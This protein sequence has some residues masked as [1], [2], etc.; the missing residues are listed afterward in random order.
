MADPNDDGQIGRRARRMRLL[1]SIRENTN[2]VYVPTDEG[3]WSAA[4]HWMSVTRALTEN[5]PRAPNP[6]GFKGEL[7]PPQATMLRAMLDL[8]RCPVLHLADGSLAQGSDEKTRPP[9]IQ[10]KWG[11]IGEKFSF[12]K[13]VLAMALV[14]AT[15]RPRALPEMTNVPMIPDKPGLNKAQVTTDAG[16]AGRACVLTT[17]LNSVQIGFMPELTCRF[18][19]VLDVTMVIAASAVISQW[20]E[21]AKRF[22]SLRYFIIENVATLREFE[23]LYRSGKIAAYSM[24]MVKAGKVTARFQVDGEPAPREKQTQR[25][26]I[27]AI[28]AVIEGVTLARLII[29]DFDTIKLGSDDCFLPSLFTWIIS[30]T[31]RTTT[32]RSGTRRE[33][34]AAGMLGANAHSFPILGAALDDVTY[35]ALRL[36]CDPKY[37]EGYLNTTTMIFRRIFVR[38]GQAAGI[39]RD[40]GVADDIVE[41]VNG[42]AVATAADTL[43]I[44]ATSVGDIIARILSD[45]KGKYRSAVRILQLLSHAREALAE[46]SGKEKD[47]ERISALRLAIKSG[48]ESAVEEALADMEGP[49][50][51]VAASLKSLEEWATEQR[52]TFGKTLARMRDNIREKQCQC[53]MIP[54]GGEADEGGDSE[55]DAQNAFILNCCQIV[56]CETCITS[57]E[58]GKYRFISRCPNCAHNLDASKDLIRVGKELSLEEALSDE[59]ILAEAPANNAGEALPPEPS[60][61]ASEQNMEQKLDALDNPRL[62]AL[63]QLLIGGPEGQIDCIRNERVSP[64]VTGLLKGTK[65]IPW[66]ATCPR[67]FLIFT[68]HAESTKVVAAALTQFGI[69]HQILKGRRQDKDDIREKFRTDPESNVLLVTA[70][71]QCSGMHLPWVSHVILYHGMGDIATKSQAVAR[72]QRLGRTYSGECIELVNEVEA[73]DL[74]IAPITPTQ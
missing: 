2:N 23:N 14:C 21:N 8:E 62:K 26:L 55:D 63:I 45:R 9:I 69:A 59:V 68:M 70:K 57:K 50:T 56:V 32:V 15:R 34:T 54:F 42:D 53:C 60:T 4:N 27:G 46:K 11:L 33:A 16:S 38:G 48:S 37:V 67:K 29:D 51:E 40:L 13:T 74:Q 6:T 20:A 43:G 61:E 49:S 65:E 58:T 10:T 36:Q 12:G 39:L 7:Y 71:E 64:H 28:G 31:R 5:D 30:A 18:S 22:T 3:A 35:G 1:K 19:R 72:I 25:S 47:K 73:A 24:V 17:G 44:N 66:P 41:M 52:D